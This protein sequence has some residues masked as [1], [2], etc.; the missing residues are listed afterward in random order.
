M[1]QVGLKHLIASGVAPADKYVHDLDLNVM[2]PGTL[3]FW[4]TRKGVTV[5][6]GT[7]YAQCPYLGISQVVDLDGD[8]YGD[9]LRDAWSGEVD[10]AYVWNVT[11]EVGRV[12]LNKIEEIYFKCTRKETPYTLSFEWRNDDTLNFSPDNRWNYVDVS[13]FPQDYACDDCDD[14]IDPKEVA[15]GIA[16]QFYAKY[17]ENST[18]DSIFLK[19]ALAQQRKDYAIDVM[20]IMEKEKQWCFTTATD[21]CG[22]CTRISAIKTF[23]IKANGGTIPADIDTVIPGSLDPSDNTK[24]FYSQI[25]RIIK[26]INKA[27]VDNGVTGHAVAIEGITGTGRPCDQ[28]VTIL[29]NS[30]E[31]VALEDNTDA[32]I[33]PC[34]PGNDEYNPYTGLSFTNQAE[35]VGCTTGTTFTPTAG[36]RVI[37]KGLQVKWDNKVKHDRKSWYNTDVRITMQED[38]EFEVYAFRTMQDIVVPE[39]MGIQIADAM[40]DMTVTGRGMDYGPSS[41]DLRTLY[42]QNVSPRFWNNTLGLNPHGLYSSISIHHGSANNTS[43]ANGF[44]NVPKATTIIYCESSD[45]VTLAAIEGILN[46]WMASLPIPKPAIDLSNGTDDDQTNLVVNSVGTVTQTPVDDTGAVA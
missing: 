28:G 46:P 37:G 17:V 45:T 3:V 31:S 15:C 38:A 21:A 1:R 34:G 30:C 14:G 41:V 42:K 44:Q 25:N 35:C 4:N 12:G 10:G 20:P 33:T 26:I 27:F 36:V 40:L 18:T 29:I 39:L 24:S 19:N 9:A 43:N 7:T 5:G 11:S 8:N 13:V 22:D 2:T 32:D 16:N 6:A 23:V